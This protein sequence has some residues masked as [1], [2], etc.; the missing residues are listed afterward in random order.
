MSFGKAAP[1]SQRQLDPAAWLPVGQGNGALPPIELPTATAMASSPTMAAV[2][3]SASS[4]SHSKSLCTNWVRGPLGFHMPP[5]HQSDAAPAAPAAPGC[6]ASVRVESPV[7]RTDPNPWAQLAAP[8]QEQ[9]QKEVPGKA[10]LP[11]SGPWACMQDEVDS[12]PMWAHRSCSFSL[13]PKL[14]GDSQIQ[15]LQPQPQR[16]Q[17]RRP[18]TPPPPRPQQQQQQQQQ[19]RR[20]RGSVFVSREMFI[21]LHR[22]QAAVIT[23]P[24]ALTAEQAEAIFEDIWQSP[25]MREETLDRNGRRYINMN[26]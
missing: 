13:L 5:P 21:D 15:Q 3:P 6:N 18:P 1:V 25:S 19:Q 4:G 16:Q 26:F 20:S 23:A 17:A 24:L 10:A 2:T 14:N 11:G 12:K 7:W 8:E 9:E 22:M